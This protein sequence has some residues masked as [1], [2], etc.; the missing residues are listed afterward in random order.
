MC[1]IEYIKCSNFFPH[2]KW[3]PLPTGYNLH[4]KKTDNL[5]C[6]KLSQIIGKIN[7]LKM[8]E[9]CWYDDLTKKDELQ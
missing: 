6:L 3:I 4:W 7:I 2:S 5:K 1:N 8:C 9:K